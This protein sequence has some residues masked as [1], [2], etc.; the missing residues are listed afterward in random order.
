MMRSNRCS[1]SRKLKL[2]SWGRKITNWKICL[3][4][5]PWNRMISCWE[6]MKAWCSILMIVLLQRKHRFRVEIT[7]Q[8]ATIQTMHLLIQRVGLEG[9]SPKN[10]VPAKPDSKKVDYKT[11]K[12]NIWKKLKEHL[13]SLQTKEILVVMTKLVLSKLRRWQF[14]A[15]KLFY[16]SKTISN[17]K[18]HQL[19]KQNLTKNSGKISIVLRISINSLRKIT[20]GWRNLKTEQIWKM[21][22]SSIK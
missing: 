2:N 14:C 21:S 3:R 11:V 9:E 12:S 13:T 7:S 15:K 6:L 20:K 19:S 17:L 4:I 10:Q 22:N 16:W 18:I 1:V 5:K 8:D